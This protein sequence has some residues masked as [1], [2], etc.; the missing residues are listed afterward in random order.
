[1]K[2]TP[3]KKGGKKKTTTK[4]VGSTKAVSKR[5]SRR[6]KEARPYV[7][8]KTAAELGITCLSPA[9]NAAGVCGKAVFWFDYE[10]GEKSY[11]HGFVCDEHRVSNRVEKLAQPQ[12]ATSTV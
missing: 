4:K 6:T 3:V 8:P 10:I 1:M 5:T 9:S 12:T 11:L 2:N 7:M